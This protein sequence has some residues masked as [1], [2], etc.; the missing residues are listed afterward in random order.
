MS[1]GM[2]T[3]QNILS[4]TIRDEESGCLLYTGALDKDGYPRISLQGKKRMGSDA[5]YEMVYG[6]IPEGQ[7]VDHI[8]YVRHCLEP[9][10]LRAL[11]HREN[12]L[13][14]KTNDEKRHRRLKQ[15]LDAYPQVHG[16]PVLLT[17][18]EL[19]GLWECSCTGNV[20]TY[21]LTMSDAFQNEFCYERFKAGQGRNP[22]LYAIGIHVALIDK[23]SNEDE[24]RETQAEDIMTLVA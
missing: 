12:V 19:Q 1:R 4:K 9:T 16:F 24:Q 3:L 18:P 10:H 20:K 21:L 5:V 22:D 11:T 23:L 17:L 6:A 2:N 15:F 14:S 7:E 13:H 8:C